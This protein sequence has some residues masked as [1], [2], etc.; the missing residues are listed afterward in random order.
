MFFRR[1]V[2]DRRKL[3]LYFHR[4]FTHLRSAGNVTAAVFLDHDAGS[5]TNDNS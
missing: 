3:I 4:R 5:I 2:A 1:P